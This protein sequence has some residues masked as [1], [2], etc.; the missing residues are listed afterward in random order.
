[1][2]EAGGTVVGTPTNCGFAGGRNAPSSPFPGIGYIWDGS[3]W[4]LVG[5]QGE[6]ALV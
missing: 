5:N 6:V 2:N 1:M 3:A 4:F